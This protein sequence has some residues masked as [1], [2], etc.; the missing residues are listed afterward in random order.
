MFD[1]VLVIM[2]LYYHIL[3]KNPSLQNRQKSDLIKVE[4]KMYI[5]KF[6]EMLRLGRKNKR[7][8]IQM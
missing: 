1:V 5:E 8:T 2:F 4:E 7:K 6:G 3:E